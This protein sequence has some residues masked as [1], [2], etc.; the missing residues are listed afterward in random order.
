MGWLLR[1]SFGPNLRLVGCDIWPDAVRASRS[2]LGVYDEVRRAD[3]R[4]FA[5]LCEVGRGVLWC[6]GDILEHLPYEAAFAL[7]NA[8]AAEWLLI[9]VPVGPYPQG[10]S[11]NPADEH[12]WTFYP[13]HIRALRAHRVVKVIITPSIET[14]P[15]YTDL[16]DRRAYEAPKL[17]MGS[18]LLR[19]STIRSERGLCRKS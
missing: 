1:L 4:R 2:L 8:C 10:P 5:R 15:T 19:R 3:A 11:I 13:S 9:R 16:R 6:F 12:L 7:L 18:F 17:Y 14:H